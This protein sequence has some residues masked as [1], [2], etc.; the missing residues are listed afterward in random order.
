MSRTNENQIYYVSV[1]FLNTDTDKK[2]SDDIF[3]D[4]RDIMN[5]SAVTESLFWGKFA[6]DL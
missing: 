3:T 6:S 5:T 2:R 4:N 1:Q